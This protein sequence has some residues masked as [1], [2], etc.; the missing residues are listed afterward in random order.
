MKIS[1]ISLHLRGFELERIF[2]ECWRSPR[3]LQEILKRSQRIWKESWRISTGSWRTLKESWRNWQ[4]CKRIPKR[5]RNNLAE[6]PTSCKTILKQLLNIWTSSWSLYKKNVEI[7]FERDEFIE[8]YSDR[9]LK[10]N[11]FFSWGEV[12]ATWPQKQMKSQ[13][14]Q[15]NLMPH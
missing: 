13:K 4:G 7:L 12:K 6:S 2:S 8:L 5:W 10:P 14:N 11:C 15:S 3:Q 9:T 1:C